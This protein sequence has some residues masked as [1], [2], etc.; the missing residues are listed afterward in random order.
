M[1]SA[2]AV[3]A[4]LKGFNQDDVVV[5]LVGKHDGVV[6]AAGADREAAHVIGVEFSHGFDAH[7]ELF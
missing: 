1:R 5:N 3:V 6:P 7:D 4:G 2:V